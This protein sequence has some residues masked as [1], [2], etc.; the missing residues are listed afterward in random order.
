MYELIPTKDF[1]CI[2]VAEEVY[3]ILI[4]CCPSLWQ[5]VFRFCY[6][7]VS[8]ILSCPCGLWFYLLT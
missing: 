5:F 3:I 2:H 7:T 4:T 8:L 6:F 1:V